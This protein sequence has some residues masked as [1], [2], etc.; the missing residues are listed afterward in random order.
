MQPLSQP[1]CP[2]PSIPHFLSLYCSGLDDITLVIAESPSIAIDITVIANKEAIQ[3]PVVEP[4]NHRL[5]DIRSLQFWSKYRPYLLGPMGFKEIVTR[6]LDMCKLLA[7]GVKN[8]IPHMTVFTV[9]PTLRKLYRAIEILDRCSIVYNELE[10]AA[11]AA[12][13]LPFVNLKL[14]CP[15]PDFCEVLPG[16]SEAKIKA[17]RKDNIL[18]PSSPLFE[19]KRRK[20]N[21]ILGVKPKGRFVCHL[22]HQPGHIK[23]NCP[24]NNKQNK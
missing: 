22:C 18:S 8:L 23:K 20:E 15:H 2:C 14:L 17:L 7:P 16:F 21:P 5:I 1:C 11:A 13:P 12:R 24:K 9:S 19:Y 10:S 6:H 4:K 3:W